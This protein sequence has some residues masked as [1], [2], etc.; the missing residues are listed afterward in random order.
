MMKRCNACHNDLPL[1]SF[2]ARKDRNGSRRSTCNRCRA[3]GR[4]TPEWW[5]Q[6]K[7]GISPERYDAM[8]EA[9][10][11]GCAICNGTNP[12]DRPLFVDHDHACCPGVKTCWKCVRGLLCHKCNSALG[13]FNDD[14][15]L[16]R[17]A[18]TYLEGV[19]RG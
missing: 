18:M 10:G 15:A 8:L 7:Y 1:T 9:Q 12:S 3:E 5:R 2:E 17:A 6:H 11:G 14:P 4:F 16:L 19:N 13:M